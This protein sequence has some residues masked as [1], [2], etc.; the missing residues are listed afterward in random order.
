MD[1]IRTHYC[2]SNAFIEEEKLCT[3]EP[4]L[5]GWGVVDLLKPYPSLHVLPCQ[6]RGRVSTA[7][8]E[9]TRVQLHAE[10]GAL[11]LRT[12]APEVR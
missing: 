6:F 8:S 12:T 10:L 2:S 4:W 1:A 3:P 7:M 9:S 11:R 5:L